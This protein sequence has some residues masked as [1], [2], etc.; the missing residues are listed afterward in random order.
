MTIAP[1]P[2]HDDTAF[3]RNRYARVHDIRAVGF[4]QKTPAQNEKEYV[5]AARLFKSYV[6]EDLKLVERGSALEFGYGLGHYTRHC[7]DLGFKSYHGLDFAAPAGPSL[8]PTFTYGK[9]DVGAPLDLKKRFD[10]VMAIDVLF[11]ITDEPRFE[12]ALTNIKK[13]AARII[14]VTGRT[15]AERIAAHVIHRD[16]A[17]FKRLGTLLTISPWRDTALMRF[18]VDR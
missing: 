16:L 11:H 18:R 13:H 4:L 6:N 2:K 17:R 12:Q 9:A 14:Y 7:H 15:R 8:G 3:W 1:K 10:L 5:Q